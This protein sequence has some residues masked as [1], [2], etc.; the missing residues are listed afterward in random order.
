M[1]Q[2][3]EHSRTRQQLNLKIIRLKMEQGRTSLLYRGPLTWNA[4]PHEVRCCK[5]KETFLRKLRMCKV[6]DKI[7]YQKE[8]AIGTN[9]NIDFLYY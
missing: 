4:I 7:Q 6:S 5:N 9:K 1:F 2:K 3:E 8:A